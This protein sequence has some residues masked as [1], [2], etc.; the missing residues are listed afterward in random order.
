MGSKRPATELTNALKGR[1]VYLPVDVQ[2]NAEILPEKLL[3]I[4]SFVII[5][6]G[7]PTYKR[8]VWFTLIDLRKIHS[9]LL[10]LKDNNYLYKNIQA[11][12]IEELEQVLTNRLLEKEEG[13]ENQIIYRMGLF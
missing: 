10:W 12:T 11:F 2:A 7:Q 1:I 3:N 9:T 8:N 4:D 5:V 13:Q 6:N